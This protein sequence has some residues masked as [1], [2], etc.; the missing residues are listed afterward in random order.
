M[1][2]MKSKI[3]KPSPS[4]NA[5]KI[6]KHLIAVADLKA[7]VAFWEGIRAQHD[8]GASESPPVTACI[9]K[10]L[11]RISYNGRVWDA[12]TGAEVIP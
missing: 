2:P 4:G 1:M 11:Y 8:L 12:G 10:K 5:V 7:A 9:D 3:Q 6:G